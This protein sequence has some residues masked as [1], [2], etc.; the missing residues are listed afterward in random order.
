MDGYIP[1]VAQGQGVP[2]DPSVWWDGAATREDAINSADDRPRLPSAGRVEAFSD[3][4]IAI[5]ITLLVLDLRAPQAKGRFL[6][7]LGAEWPSYAAYL[8]TFL[9]I[10]TIWLTHHSL[11]TRVARV[12]GPCCWRTWPSCCSSRCCRS[13]PR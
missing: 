4:V 1:G 3:G 12:D 2:P 13:P 10:G 11:F 6:H 5:A 8:A 9:I 7:D